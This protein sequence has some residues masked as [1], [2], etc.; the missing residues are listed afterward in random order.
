MAV[1][2]TFASFAAFLITFW[3]VSWR[4]AASDND[5]PRESPSETLEGKSWLQQ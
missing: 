2:L 4:A 1:A 3:F 5:R